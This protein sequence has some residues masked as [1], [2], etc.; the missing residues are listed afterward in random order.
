MLKECTEM[1]KLFPSVLQI[2]LI[3]KKQAEEVKDILFSIHFNV[4][5]SILISKVTLLGKC[6]IF[7]S[8]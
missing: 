5:M 7:F 2:I 6:L 1:E 4:K 8:S 3:L